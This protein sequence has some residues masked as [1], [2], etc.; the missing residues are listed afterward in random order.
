M[1]EVPSLRDFGGAESVSVTQSNIP[2]GLKI[3][4]N[5]LVKILIHKYLNF[6]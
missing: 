5:L 2:S 6:N 3:I 1:L 4:H